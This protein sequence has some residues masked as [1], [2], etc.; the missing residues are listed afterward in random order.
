MNNYHDYQ[1][2]YNAQKKQNGKHQEKL[3][4]FSNHWESSQVLRL[5]FS[6]IKLLH[7]YSW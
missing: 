5:S 2:A 6:H 7:V 3:I 4:G 1:Q